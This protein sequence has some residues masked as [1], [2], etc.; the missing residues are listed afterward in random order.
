MNL[1]IAYFIGSVKKIMSI[2]EALTL[3]SLCMEPK[4]QVILLRTLIHNGQLPDNM[5]GR[6]LRYWMGE[7]GLWVGQENFRRE[8]L[9]PSLV[10]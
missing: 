1:L 2:I 10:D 6:E 3:Y 7:I 9:N 5:A 8:R 4:L